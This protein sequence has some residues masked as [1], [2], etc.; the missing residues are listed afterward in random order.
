MDVRLRIDSVVLHTSRG[1]HRYDFPGPCTVVS[2]PIGTGKSSLLELLKYALGGNGVITPV[3]AAEVTYVTVAV[4]IGNNPLYLRR[5]IGGGSARVVEILDS[6]DGSIVEVVPVRPKINQDTVGDMLLNVLGI[7]RVSIPRARSRA[8]S[9][10]VPLTFNDL[11][12]YL[13]VEQK[14]IDRSVVHHTEVFREP[15][16]RAIFELMFGLADPELL[17]VEVALGRLRDQSKEADERAQAVR[18]FLATSTFAEEETIRQELLRVNDDRVRARN[19]LES[20]RDEIAQL[21]ENHSGLR[22]DLAAAERDLHVTR[23]AVEVCRNEVEYRAQSLSQLHLDR[24]REDRTVA[25]LRRLS[26]LEFVTCPRCLQEL[27]SDRANV[28]TCIVCLQPDPVEPPVKIEDKDLADLDSQIEDFSELLDRA[29]KNAENANAT[30]VRAEQR[31]EIIR[32]RFDEAT[33][34]AVTPRFEEISILSA[35]VANAEAED[36]RLRELLTFFDQSR[37][38]AAEVNRLQGERVEMEARLRELRLRLQARRSVVERLG[39]EFD[40]MIRSLGVPW[41]THATID[42]TNYLPLVNGDKYD[43]LAV[44]GGTKTIVTVAYHLTLLRYALTA[45]DTFLPQMLII[46]TPR[47]N[48]GANDADQEIGNRIF[49]QIETLANAS[50]D[51]VQFIIADNDLP[52]LREK[53]KRRPTSW[54]SSIQLSYT[55]PLLPDVEHPG[56]EAIEAGAIPTIGSL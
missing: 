25:A 18:G 39:G 11:Y 37:E 22:D 47:K 7:P 10:T 44:A 51:R 24:E 35:N 3:V 15:K 26:P 29:Q 45:R 13:Y 31:Y 30:Y 34:S 53:S 42:A 14:E 28:G 20:L 41:A 55:T 46:D 12:S 23:Q 48:L 5:G 43:I 4:K 6:I 19:D 33:A 36:R 8:T 32:K 49:S 2:G 56:P 54:Y 21:T 17:E 50:P 27:D 16:R 40:E 38:L 9:A 1:R 52:V